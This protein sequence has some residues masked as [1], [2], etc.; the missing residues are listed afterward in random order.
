MESGTITRWLK[1]EGDRVEKGEPLYEVDTEKVT[2]EV[3]AETDGTLL[4]ILAPEGAEI[5]VGGP[6]CVLGEP[7]EEVPEAPAPQPADQAPPAEAADEGLAAS[8]E[9]PAEAPGQ[10][11]A[12]EAAASQARAEPAPAAAQAGAQ[13]APAAAAPAGERVKASPLARRIARE[14]G[15]DLGSIAGTGPD[16]R[17]VAEDVERAAAAPATAAPAT[18]AAAATPAILEPEVVKLT[19]I[20]KTIARRLSEAWAAPHFAIARSV[21]MR[22]AI[23]LRE[24][25]L[26]RTPEGAA[27]PTYSDVLT[28]LAAVA[29]L[30]HP[31]VNAHYAGAEVRRF[32]TANIGIA[33]AI[34]NGLVVPVIRGVER[35]TI[36]EVAAARVDLVARTRE[37]KLQPADVEGGTFTISNLGMFGV[38]RFTAVIN[39]PQVAILAVGAIEDRVVAVDGQPTVQ[40]RMDLS[41]SCDHRALDGATAAEFL[42]TLA[43][44]LEEPALAL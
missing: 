31:D 25:L 4:E 8:A 20:R 14:R 43:E 26:E 33:V 42:R 2:Q 5:P 29:L 13:P 19:T 28:K 18:P 40:P 44:L 17:I 7:G 12:H 24:R 21:D 3:E 15:L 34:P 27:R 41:L 9:A 22:G 36:A 32:P 16:G 37:N 35:L 39:P 11:P 10:E 1:A 38:E 30:R 23:A 6:V